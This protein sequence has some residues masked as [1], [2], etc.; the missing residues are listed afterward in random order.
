MLRLLCDAA[1]C[2]TILLLMLLLD[3]TLRATPLLCFFTRCFSLSAVRLFFAL[4]AGLMIC[5]AMLRYAR[6]TLR[7][8]RNIYLDAAAITPALRY[9]A[10]LTPYLFS[11]PTMLMLARAAMMPPP[12]RRALRHAAIFFFRDI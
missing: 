9:A 3:D 4:M 12:L 8:P 5:R 11:S 1:V 2:F 6:F 7:L 10:S